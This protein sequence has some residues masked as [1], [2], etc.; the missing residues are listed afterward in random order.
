[1]SMLD[2]S[3]SDLNDLTDALIVQTVRTLVLK[4]DPWAQYISIDET[5]TPLT[6]VLSYRAVFLAFNKNVNALVVLFDSVTLETITTFFSIC[7]F[8]NGSF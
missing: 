7:K 2:E 5:E 6:G 1:M 3:D 8:Q 4:Q